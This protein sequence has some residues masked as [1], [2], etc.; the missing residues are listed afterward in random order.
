MQ[1]IRRDFTV[2]AFTLALALTCGSPFLTAAHAQEP[3]KPPVPQTQP[4]P[5]MPDQTP[6]QAKSASWTGTIVKDGDG[7]SL[8]ASSGSMF[9][10]DDSSKAQQFEGK[11]VKV[12][13]QL[14]EQAKMIHVESIEGSEG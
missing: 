9:K 3:G 8:K 1:S 5:Q 14:D 12:T 4:Q 6:A 13:G 2:G 7:Y 11:T 10:L